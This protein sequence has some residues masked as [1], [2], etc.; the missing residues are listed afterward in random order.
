[1]Q[2]ILRKNPLT[3]FQMLMKEVKTSD[4]N[5]TETKAEATTYIQM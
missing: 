3:W 2:Q 4:H 1:M 5:A